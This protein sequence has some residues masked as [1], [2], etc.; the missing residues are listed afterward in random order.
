[1][2]YDRSPRAN[3]RL[4]ILALVLI[5]L[6]YYTGL[7]ALQCPRSLTIPDLYEAS[8]SELQ[9]G[10][11]NGLFSSVDLVNAYIAR[12][13]EVNT[14][15]P[16]LRAVIE[17]NLHAVS[18]ARLLDI[19]RRTKGPRG[20]LH[21]I[22]ILLKDNIATDV[23]IDGMNTTAGSYALLGSAPPGD[24]TVSAKLRAAGAILLGKTNMSEWASHRGRV[25]S[26]FSGRGGQATCPYLPLSDPSGSSSGSGSAVAVGLAAASLGTETDGSIVLPSSRNNVVGIKP[27]VGLTS[28]AGVIPISRHQDSV[29]P[30]ARSVADAAMILSIISGRD[31]L[32][33]LTLGQPDPVPDFTKALRPGG[34]RGVRLGVPRR[35]LGKSLAINAA[36][37]A[38]IEVLKHLGAIVVDPADFAN[39]EELL[40]VRKPSEAVVMETEF[41]IGVEEYISNLKAVPSGVKTI[42]DLIDFNI[43][44]ADQELIPPF[45]DSQSRLYSS[46][47]RTMDAAYYAAL[48]KVQE[49]GRAEGIDAALEKHELDAFVIP[50]DSYI[51]T[52]AAIAG[53]PLITVPLGFQA[54]DAPATEAKPTIRHGPGLP[55]GLAF[56]GTAYSEFQLI[57]YAYAYEQA[58][59]TRL[60]KRAYAAAIP[61]TQL[62]DVIGYSRCG[63]APLQMRGSR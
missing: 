13:D 52:P 30:M 54:E 22:P 19:E 34:L 12:I 10:L 5:W 39:A 43:E 18:Q 7:Q 49:M 44:H 46:Q 57:G 41:R 16:K 3:S 47:N 8:I 9:C 48:K 31:R 32:D 17:V 37:N 27:T 24:A 62:G 25:P 33:N 36:F 2:A 1:M 60:Q 53:Y 29:G 40:K 45:Y 14:R 38:S 58:T 61:K 59:Q 4:L 51:R 50:A 55:F 21:G 26:G 35:F 20:P 63:A 28:R 15:G 23:D 6:Y 42:K 11:N 56:L